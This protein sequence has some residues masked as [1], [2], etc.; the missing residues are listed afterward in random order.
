MAQGS[1]PSPRTSCADT[2]ASP[3]PCRRCS[4]SA[5]RC[6]RCRR[7]CW[8]AGRASAALREARAA[9]R[10]SLPRMLAAL[11]ADGCWPIARC[12]LHR[13]FL[14]RR[15]G[16]GGGAGHRAHQGRQ[17]TRSGAAST[18]FSAMP[19]GSTCRRRRP[20]RSAT[21]WSR[22]PTIA[23]PNLFELHWLTGTRCRERD[24]CARASGAAAGAAAT[25]VVTSA[26][27]TDCRRRRRCWS[28]RRRHIEHQT[29]HAQPASPTAPATCWPGCCSA[30]CSTGMCRRGGARRQP[31]QTS[32]ACSPPARAADVLQ[33]S[34]L[35]PSSSHDA[36]ADM[37]EK[38]KGALAFF[39]HEAAGGLGAGGGGAGRAAHQQ[40][41]AG[42]ALR[43][44]F[45]DTPVGVRV[46]AA[47]ARQAAAAVDQRRPDGGVLLSG[48]PRD[49]ARAAAG[50]AVHLRPGGAA[51]GGRGRR[52]GGA[53]AD[54]R[55]LQRR[56]PGRAQGLGDSGR[57]RHRLRRRRA[58]AARAA[59][60][61]LAQDVPAGAG[62]P[63]RPR[64][65]P[66]HRAVL[67]GRPVAGCRW[68]WL[69]PGIAV[70]LAAQRA[71]R[72]A[73]GALSAD[74]HL[75][76]GVRAEVGRARDAGRRGGRASPSR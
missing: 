21:G 44:L 11:E 45:C 66:H 46:G 54:L 12:G 61:A 41:A 51:G 62:H 1:S 72:D 74:R 50:R 73:A 33:L 65:H 3:P 25:V 47:R 15:R 31:A 7:C 26:P 27:Q 42:L 35:K 24:R 43:A 38:L 20:R 53:G 63:R 36:D 37:R 18:R 64:R 70:L 28:T 9:A 49:Q 71:R 60:A 59:R 13:I 55:R 57:H 32:T 30:T 5:T 8:R 67:H 2:S 16:R 40:L 19:G 4:G 39:H 14:R 56:R 48:R 69:R 22:W 75:H 17:S 10:R 29:P 76:L 6:G 52:H 23:T 34:A 58:G 68:R